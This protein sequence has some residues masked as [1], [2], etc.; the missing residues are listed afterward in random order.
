MAAGNGADCA[1]G[2]VLQLTEQK[3]STMAPTPPP[4]P[5][6]RPGNPCSAKGLGQWFLPGRDPGQCPGASVVITLGAPGIEGMGPGC[7]SKPHSRRR[8][9]GTQCQQETVR[10]DVGEPD[11]PDSRVC[12]CDMNGTRGL[13]EDG[14]LAARSG[15]E[16]SQGGV[17]GSSAGQVGNWGCRTVPRYLEQ[18]SRR[19][20]LGLGVLGREWGH[21]WESQLVQITCGVGL[22]VGGGDPGSGPGRDSCAHRTAALGDDFPRQQDAEVQLGSAPHAAATNAGTDTDSEAAA[23]AAAAAHDYWHPPRPPRCRT[24]PPGMPREPGRPPGPRVPQGRARRRAS[25]APT[26]ESLARAPDLRG[27]LGFWGR[28]SCLRVQFCC[29]GIAGAGRGRLRPGRRRP[30]TQEA[31]AG[32]SKER[33]LRARLELRGAG[34][35]AR[36]EL[37]SSAQGRGAR[38]V[39]ALSR[40]GGWVR[41]PADQGAS[42][43]VGVGVGWGDTPLMASFKLPTRRHPAYKTPADLRVSSCKLQPLRRGSGAGCRSKL[44]GQGEMCSEGEEVERVSKR[45][46]QVESTVGAEALRL[47]LPGVFQGNKT[48][49]M[50]KARER[51]EKDLVG[52]VPSRTRELVLP[53]LAWSHVESQLFPGWRQEGSLAGSLCPC[54]R[55]NKPPLLERPWRRVSLNQGAGGRTKDNCEGPGELTMDGWHPR[56]HLACCRSPRPPVRGENNRPSNNPASW[57]CRPTFSPHGDL[58]ER[59]G[60]WL[61]AAMLTTAPSTHFFIGY[62]HLPARVPDRHARRL[63]SLFWVEVKSVLQEIQV[64]AILDSS[65]SLCL[66]TPLCSK[67]SGVPTS[68]WVTD[69]ALTSLSL[70]TLLQPHRPPPCSP[71]HLA[72]PC[73]RAFAPAPPKM[74][75][76]PNSRTT[77]TRLGKET[78]RMHPGLE[79]RMVVTGGGKETAGMRGFWGLG[80]VGGGSQCCYMAIMGVTALRGFC[81]V[82]R[83]ADSSS[84]LHPA[85]H[86]ILANKNV[87]GCCPLSPG[88]RNTLDLRRIS[89]AATGPS[90]HTVFELWLVQTESP[91]PAQSLVHSRCPRTR[92]QRQVRSVGS[93]VAQTEPGRALARFSVKT[94]APITA[95]L[96]SS[97][98]DCEELGQGRP[99]G[100]SRPSQLDPPVSPSP[101]QHQPSCTGPGKT[102]II[103][104]VV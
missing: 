48:S 64:K 104:H 8:N 57:G 81:H 93:L 43:L 2:T 10:V 97:S 77:H 24:A 103:N 29:V 38:A 19:T 4:D 55:K 85:P 7:C 49:G 27:A 79:V 58:E 54:P 68:L 101:G 78:S 98:A 95:T 45:L 69:P 30:S 17:G 12:T 3:C 88:G 60:P 67:P 20:R 13:G 94:A 11:G 65:L 26:L 1:A 23:A 9:I 15:S 41:G 90:G 59:G 71:T 76:T 6:L 52:S 82:K 86:P 14:S 40:V 39:S 25:L 100:Q 50:D 70:L 89:T 96:T 28:S 35:C 36:M 51:G 84:T 92:T 56:E 47:E 42:I 31:P 34:S 44:G 91:P 63:G 87:S 83:N 66:T 73:P 46:Y 75:T 74:L 33:G 32:C 21:D 22:R 62:L 5:R 80:A 53:C 102:A 16:P 18:G 61:S 37:L 72:Q 99:H